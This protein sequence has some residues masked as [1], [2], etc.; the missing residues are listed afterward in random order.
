MFNYAAEYSGA[1][2]TQHGILYT[3]L[4]FIALLAKPVICSLADKYAA[5]HHCLLFFIFTTIL[6]YGSLV[7]YPF[8]PDLIQN[9]KNAVWILYCLAALVGNTSM[10][11]VNSIGDSLAINSCQKRDIS[12]GEYRLW[13]PVGFG[14]FGAIWGIANEIPTLPKYTP[15]ILTMILILIINSLLIAFWYDKEEFKVINRIIPHV[16]DP[17]SIANPN[18][19]STNFDQRLVEA[20]EVGASQPAPKVRRLSLLWKLGQQQSSIFAYIFLFTFCGVMTGIHWQFFFKYLEQVASKDNQSFSTIATLAL[21]VQALGG[22]LVF[23]MLSG[24][25]LKKLGSSLTLVLC[26]FSFAARYL[27]Y[28]YLIPNINIYWILFVELLQG[29]AFGLMYSVLTHQ[30][31]YY[32]EKIDSIVAN[33]SNP[34]NLQLKNSLHATLQGVLGAAFEVRFHSSISV[35]EFT[36]LLI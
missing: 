7:I 15:G 28:A 6:G 9:H 18:Y 34:G 4:P 32:S 16:S 3:V 19:G 22:E 27:L 24:A 25:I 23:F 30:A 31:N 20:D 2:G 26:L 5:H 36:R 29:P 13:G 12:Y 17:N 21:P 8:F 33:S 14:I 11:I 1:S 10:C 35:S